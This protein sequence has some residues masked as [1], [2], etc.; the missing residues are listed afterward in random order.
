MITLKDQGQNL[1]S[2]QGDVVTQLGGIAY[3]SMLL[4]I[5]AQWDDSHVSISSESK[6]IK[7][8]V[9]DLK[10]DLRWA[11]EGRGVTD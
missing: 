6:V 11:F 1:I 8:T 4:I 2:V 10:H 9:V 7:Q 3:D 5:E